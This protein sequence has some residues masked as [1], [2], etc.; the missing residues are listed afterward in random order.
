M[1]KQ[2][3]GTITNQDVLAMYSW[4]KFININQWTRFTSYEPKIAEENALNGNY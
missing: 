4:S 3:N 1:N 2:A